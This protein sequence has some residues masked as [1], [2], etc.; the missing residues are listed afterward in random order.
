MDHI[1][2]YPHNCPA[3]IHDA[4]ERTSDALFEEHAAAVVKLRAN[5]TATP[6]ARE[7]RNASP[8]AAARHRGARR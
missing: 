3:C 8:T 5:A 1:D 4:F 6:W 2:A 7:K